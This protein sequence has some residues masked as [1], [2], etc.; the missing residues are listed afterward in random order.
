MLPV[1]H[2]INKFSINQVRLRQ[3]IRILTYV[4]S[5]WRSS[6]YKAHARNARMWDTRSKKKPPV[7]YR[8][9]SDVEIQHKFWTLPNFCKSIM[10][11]VSIRMTNKTSI[12]DRFKVHECA[13]QSKTFLMVLNLWLLRWAL[14]LTQMKPVAM[15]LK[16]RFY[17]TRNWTWACKE[18]AASLSETI[19]Y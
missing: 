19:A 18:T 14:S 7:M 4:H 9:I 1:N 6:R 2:S 8:S 15:H 5:S 17:C 10:R 3:L 13:D 16:L 11:F 12:S